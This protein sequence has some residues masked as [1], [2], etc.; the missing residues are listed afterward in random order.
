MSLPVDESWWRPVGKW[1]ARTTLQ[2]SHLRREQQQ[3]SHPSFW[4]RH[5]ISPCSWSVPSK[6]SIPD[7]YFIGAEVDSK[8]R[9]LASQSNSQPPEK[10]T[11]SS[12]PGD[13]WNCSWDVFLAANLS[14]FSLISNWFNKSYDCLPPA[15]VS[16][17]IPSER[18]WMSEGKELF[19]QKSQKKT[20]LSGH[21]GLWIFKSQLEYWGRIYTPPPCLTGCKFPVAYLNI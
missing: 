2:P 3:C 13:V 14:L 10:S 16:S 5:I 18:Q 17:P 8:C 15:F 7:D 9:H 21:F 19:I 1:Q 20:L 4:S 12:W 11:K 6:E